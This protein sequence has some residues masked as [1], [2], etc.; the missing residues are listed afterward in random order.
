MPAARLPPLLG[1]SSC[2]RHQGREQPSAQV[3]QTLFSP[4]P[5]PIA[6]GHSSRIRP[7]EQLVGEWG[8]LGRRLTAP[9]SNKAPASARRLL[10]SP[11][12]RWGPARGGLTAGPTCSSRGHTHTHAQTHRHTHTHRRGAGASPL[13]CQPGREGGDGG[14]A[15]VPVAGS[16]EF[17][18]WEEAAAAGWRLLPGASSRYRYDTA[19]AESHPSAWRAES[20]DAPSAQRSHRFHRSR[21]S[22]TT[23]Y[24]RMVTVSFSLYACPLPGRLSQLIVACIH[25]SKPQYPSPPPHFHGNTLYILYRIS[26]GVGDISKLH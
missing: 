16:E 14:L 2:H 13:F 12:G 6:T 10:P 3:L 22:A 20:G 18:R 11:Y 7:W 26:L 1:T 21:D 25:S 5:L 8:L 9:S 15:A 19:H 24:H 4:T 23:H 17:P